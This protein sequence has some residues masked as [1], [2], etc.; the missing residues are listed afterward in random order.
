VTSTTEKPRDD[1][2]GTDSFSERVC[3][4]LTFVIPA[5]RCERYLR[6]A[7]DSVSHAFPGRILIADD[8][9]DDGTIAVARECVMR[10]CGR[11]EVIES[12]VRRG[13]GANLNRAVQ[14]ITTPLFAKL[15]ADDVL[16]PEFMETAFAVMS[17]QPELAVISGRELRI[18]ANDIL[19]YSPDL[20]PRVKAVPPRILAGVDACRFIILWS[21]NPCSSGT[22]YRTEAFRSVGGFDERM[23]W[24]EDW[25]LWFR[26][27]QAWQVAY[28]DMPSALYRIHAASTTAVESAH[29]RLCYGYDAV[30]RRV[31]EICPDDPSLRP[32]LRRAFMRTARAYFG[33]AKRHLLERGSMRDMLACLMHGV[34]MLYMSLSGTSWRN[35]RGQKT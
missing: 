18:T 26:F 16:L 6:A 11:V 4:D 27:A 12:T 24:G 3:R 14:Q 8:C 1:A 29:S 19:T 34:S 9:S 20:L 22:I 5:F 35:H 2:R 15:D 7:V 23:R 10:A 25:E 13:T 21:P 31:A 28:C 17:A 33:S 30:Y 32:L